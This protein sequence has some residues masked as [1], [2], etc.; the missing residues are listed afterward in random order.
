MHRPSAQAN[1]DQRQDVDEM[2]LMLERHV[3]IIELDTPPFNFITLKMAREIQE[4]IDRISEDEHIRAVIFR[5]SQKGLFSAGIDMAL[6]SHL[7][8]DPSTQT[9]IDEI[10]QAL[11]R[12]SE[13]Q[14]PTIAQLEGVALGAGFELALACDIRISAVDLTHVGL[15]EIKIGMLPSTHAIQRLASLVGK[16]AAMQMVMTGACFDA[17]NAQAKGLIQEIAP[18]D[19]LSKHVEMKAVEFVKNPP[20]A[21]RLAKQLVRGALEDNAINA[22]ELFAAMIND[23]AREGIAAMLEGREAVFVH[24]PREQSE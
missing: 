20:Q 10:T 9:A 18:P 24:E 4:R 12:V 21:T 19:V 5:P 11:I 15:P 14:V 6:L 2:G 17:P 8:D 13:L 1:S 23:D 7:I 16:A 3:E 22:D